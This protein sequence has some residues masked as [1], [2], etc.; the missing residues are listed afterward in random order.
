MLKTEFNRDDTVHAA[1]AVIINISVRLQRAI[2]P[3]P[4]TRFF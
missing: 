3:K 2:A 1:G 4:N